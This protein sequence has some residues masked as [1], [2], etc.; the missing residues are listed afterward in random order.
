M[1]LRDPQVLVPSLKIRMD[2]GR[3]VRGGRRVT[4]QVRHNNDCCD[5]I[6]WIRTPFAFRA[7]LTETQQKNKKGKGEGKG[8]EMEKALASQSN[9]T[10]MSL[11][12]YRRPA[13]GAI[14]AGA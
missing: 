1:V 3:R 8:Y 13:N 4:G 6:V 9:A 5:V 2:E 12:I 11:V 10:I 7:S 14:R